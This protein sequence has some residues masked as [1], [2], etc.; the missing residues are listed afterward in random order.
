MNMQWTA[1]T[2]AERISAVDKL[3]ETLPTAAQVAE[4]LGTSK[5]AV[6]GLAHRNGLNLG[7]QGVSPARAER[8]TANERRAMAHQA[9][10]KAKEP[11]Q[12]AAAPEPQ[13]EP[14]KVDRRAAWL[15]LPGSRSVP[16][17]EVGAAECAWPLWNLDSEPKV[18]CGAGSQSSH[19]YCPAH[20]RLAYPRGMPPS[21]GERG[22][23]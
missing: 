13:P 20:M 3:L 7:Q 10:E 21:M 6:L 11:R 8:K 1:M 17:H 18:F 22:S 14:D 4:K 9:K 12:R 16:L 2:T 23:E 19:H 15:A 5:S